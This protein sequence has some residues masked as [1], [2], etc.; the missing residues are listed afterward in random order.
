MLQVGVP[1]VGN[2]TRVVHKILV[3]T[4][5]VI[6]VSRPGDESSQG[7]EYVDHRKVMLDVIGHGGF[8]RRWQIK[9]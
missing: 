9:V 1:R 8:K 2:I 3:A 7:T 5:S 4:R 6:W